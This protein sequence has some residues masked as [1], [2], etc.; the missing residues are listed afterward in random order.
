[1]MVTLNFKVSFWDEGL[2]SISREELIILPA[3]GL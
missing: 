3:M 2:S 1:M